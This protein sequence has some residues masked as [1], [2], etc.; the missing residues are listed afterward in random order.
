M[1]LS[2]VVSAIL[3]PWIP[4]SAKLA[5]FVGAL[6][7]EKEGVEDLLEKTLDRQ[8]DHR[9]MAL[10]RSEEGVMSPDEGTPAHS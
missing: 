6:I 8:Q 3:D 10:K 9:E 7:P 5:R 1:K 2:L 4:V